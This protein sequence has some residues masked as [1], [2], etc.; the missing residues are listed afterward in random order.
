MPFIRAPKGFGRAVPIEKLEHHR[1]WRLGEQPID[2]RRPLFGNG[3]IVSCRCA[4]GSLQII[5]ADDVREWNADADADRQIR[6][7]GPGRAS[8][9]VG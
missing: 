6:S 4:Q 8:S 5:R 9:F 1:Q 3:I 2:V 7:I